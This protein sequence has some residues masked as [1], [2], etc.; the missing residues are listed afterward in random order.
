LFEHSTYSL[1]KSRFTLFTM[2]SKIKKAGRNPTFQSSQQPV[3][4]HPWS[5]IG[6][7]IFALE[8]KRLK[9]IGSL[10]ARATIRYQLKA[11]LLTFIERMQTCTLNSRDV[12]KH[13]RR[14]VV[15]LNKSK[16]FAAVKKFYCTFCHNEFLSIR[17]VD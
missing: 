5:K 10:L 8:L 4:V 15:R 13:I 7:D 2:Q 11:Y 1:E 14:T 9:I 12:N 17:M 6:N 3:P 16:A